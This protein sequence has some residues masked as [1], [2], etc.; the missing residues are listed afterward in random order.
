M[1]KDDL[2]QIKELRKVLKISNKI[3]IDACG[4]PNIYGKKGKLF[5]GKPFW[6]IYIFDGNWN[7]SKRKLRFMI[8]SQDGDQ[9]GILKLDRL[10]TI[11]ESA[12]IRE[13]G[14][15]KQKRELSPEHREKLVEAGKKFRFTNGS[16]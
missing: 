13:I 12:I 5:V 4:D 3:E 10:P 9:E 14:G 7:V 2:K 15:F 8:L 16:K 1:F 11:K 6:F